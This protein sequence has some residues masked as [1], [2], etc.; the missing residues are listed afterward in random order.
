MYQKVI[1]FDSVSRG[2]NKMV[3][4]ACVEDQFF[5]PQ[6]LTGSYILITWK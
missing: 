5:L 4:T 3:L 2:Q 1:W 6:K